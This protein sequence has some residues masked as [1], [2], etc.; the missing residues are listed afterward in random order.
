MEKIEYK[1]VSIYSCLLNNA[2]QLSLCQPDPKLELFLQRSVLPEAAALLNASLLLFY[3][4]R[5]LSHI[6]VG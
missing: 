2:R 3:A 5:A 4:L 6:Q 1:N